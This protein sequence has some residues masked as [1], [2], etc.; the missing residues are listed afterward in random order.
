MKKW[1][2]VL[3]F[4]ILATTSIFVGV[5][6]VTVSELMEGNRMQWLLLAKT[7][8]PRTISLILAGGMLSISGRI[9]QHFMQNK[10]V[11]ANTIG[12]MDSARLGI[13]VVMLFYPTGSS[14]MKAFV[15]FLFSYAGVLLFLSLSRLL[16]KGDSVILPLAGVMFG[17]VISAIAIFF[18]YHYQLIQNMS[19]WLQGHFATVMAGSYELIYLTVPVVIVL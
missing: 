12:M 10:F 16:P 9:M 17:N 3:I 19:A 18:A 14:L 11:S 4:L 5:N 8:I 7:R 15:A 1:L 6:E 13:L 2:V